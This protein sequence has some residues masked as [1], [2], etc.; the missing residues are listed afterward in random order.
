MAILL[1]VFR[2]QY[3]L[4]HQD[5]IDKQNTFLAALYEKPFNKKEELED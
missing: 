4:S 1:K 5:E 3:A 2:I